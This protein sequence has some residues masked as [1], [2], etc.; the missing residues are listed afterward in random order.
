MRIISFAVLFGTPDI[1]IVGEPLP[2]HLNDEEKA[3]ADAVVKGSNASDRIAAASF[4]LSPG[5]ASAETQK[6]CPII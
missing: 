1:E 2:H 3:D 5:Y 4:I 6:L